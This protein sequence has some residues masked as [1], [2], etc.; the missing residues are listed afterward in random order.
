MNLL[1]LGQILLS[2]I[3]EAKTQDYSFQANDNELDAFKTLELTTSILPFKRDEFINIQEL[4]LKTK[5]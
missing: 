4:F 2:S 5:T 1:L 3:S